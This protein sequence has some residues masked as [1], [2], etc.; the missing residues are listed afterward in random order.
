MH[1]CMEKYVLLTEKPQED[2][3]CVIVQYLLLNT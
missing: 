1:D 2:A 3:S